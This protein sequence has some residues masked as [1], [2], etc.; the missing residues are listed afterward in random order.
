MAAG[1]DRP[2]DDLMAELEGLGEELTELEGVANLDLDRAVANRLLWVDLIDRVKALTTGGEYDSGTI[3]KV[4]GDLGVT[5]PACDLAVNVET[6]AG[7]VR[8]LAEVVA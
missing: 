8:K 2:L 4:A 7:I 5:I 1:S 3:A 6:A